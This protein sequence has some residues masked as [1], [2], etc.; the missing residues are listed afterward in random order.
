[1]LGGMRLVSA[2]N[3]YSIARFNIQRNMSPTIILSQIPHWLSGK[4]FSKPVI[5]GKMERYVISSYIYSENWSN[6]SGEYDIGY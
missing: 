5:K 1:M 3:K 4:N 6:C 2:F